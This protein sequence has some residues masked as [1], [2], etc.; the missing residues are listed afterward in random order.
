[1]EPS[2]SCLHWMFCRSFINNRNSISLK[3]ESFKSSL[4]WI[5]ISKNYPGTLWRLPARKDSIHSSTFPLMP[6]FCNLYI[7]RLLGTVSKDLDNSR[8]IISVKSI[9]HNDSVVLYY[10][11]QYFYYL[12]G[13][14][15]WSIIVTVVS[16]TFFV[17][18]SYISISPIL[19]YL[20][21]FYWLIKNDRSWKIK[22]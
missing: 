17:Y 19:W 9:I 8:Y 18:W 10:S 20:A 1:M 14:G 5:F 2:S 15:N 7:R 12:A 6:Y 21:G 3:M 13:K 16:L 11:L 4:R 22:V